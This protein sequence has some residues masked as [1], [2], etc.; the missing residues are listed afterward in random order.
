MYSHELG[1]FTYDLDKDENLIKK[2]FDKNL[3]KSKKNYYK[4][5][6]EYLNPDGKQ[7]GFVK[8]MNIINKI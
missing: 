2:Y 8:I 1:V 6:N 3:K 7:P 5:I 4:Y